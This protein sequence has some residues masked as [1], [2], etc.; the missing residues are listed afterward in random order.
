M[1]LKSYFE[2][3]TEAGA[4]ILTLLE[5]G[6]TAA[7]IRKRLK[8]GVQRDDIV[9]ADALEVVRDANDRLAKYRGGA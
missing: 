4:L 7:E 6:V 2:L 8:D 9:S 1:N 5:K 3:V